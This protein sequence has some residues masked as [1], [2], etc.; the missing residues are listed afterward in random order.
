M[1]AAP[2][3]RTRL[4]PALAAVA[5]AG[6]IGAGAWYGYQALAHEP[7]RRVLFA[8]D[9]ASLPAEALD[10][11]AR[12]L[13][14]APAGAIAL[15]RVRESARKIP[16]VREAAVRRR[17]PDGLEITFE[18]HHALARW[19]DAALLSTRGEIFNAPGAGKLP[20]LQGP[21]ASAALMAERYQGIA[22]AVAPLASPIA[23]L[24]LSPRGAW[25]VLLESGLALDLGR[26]DFE[27]R[28]ERFV[29]AWP[30]LVA[31]GVASRHADVRYD[32]GFALRRV[33]D[34]KPASAERKPVARKAQKNKT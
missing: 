23:E 4:A 28:L 22:K 33:A 30:G 1:K 10:A 13:R 31:S 20:R 24:H 14:G 6:L 19:G 29:K 34:V 5:V 17:F 8:G 3:V 11:L 32:N 16:W 2:V 15:E 26:G 12:S 27:P 9:V 25:T 7:V 21:E 18:A